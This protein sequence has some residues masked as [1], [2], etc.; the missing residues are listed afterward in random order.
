MAEYRIG[1]P[2][3]FKIMA[4]TTPLATLSYIMKISML[5]LATLMAAFLYLPLLTQAQ[6]QSPCEWHLQLTDSG[7]DGWD[8]SAIGLENITTG[9]FFFL[10]L[11]GFVDNGT[12]TTYTFSFAPGDEIEL[13]WFVGSA[14][15]EEIGVQLFDGSNNTV[16]SATNPTGGILFNTTVVCPPC[17]LPSNV[18]EENIYDKRVKIKWT[19]GTADLTATGW[20]VIYGPAGFVPSSGL[21]DSIYVATPK[22][23]ITSL[24]PKTFYDYYI[25]QD[26]GNG[27]L[28][29]MAGPFTFQTYWS[30]DVSV[31][32]ILTPVSDC[33]L[34]SETITFAMSNPGSNPQSLIPY[35]YWVNGVPGG[36]PQPEDGYYTGVIGKDS[37][38]V[39]E[40]ETPF[41][42][43][44]PIEY[45]I[46]VYTQMEGDEDNT[47]DTL[48][49]YV[50]NVLAPPYAQSFDKWNGGWTVVN[51]PNSFSDASWE[52]G[53]PNAP[54]IQQAGDGQ[55][56][57]VTNLDGFANFAELSYIEST[58]FDF[59][60]ITQSPAIEFLINYSCLSGD[61]GA[62]IDYTLNDGTSWV[63]IGTAAN[64]GA[65]W[66]NAPDPETGLAS[67]AFAG[68][69]NGWLK[70][71]HLAPTLAGKPDV[72]F[73]FGYREGFGTSNEGVGI[74]QFRVFVPLAV[75]GAAIK[76]RSQGETSTCGLANDKF[77]LNMVNVGGQ[78]IPNGYSLFYQVDNG[79]IDSVTISNNPL[80][81]DE[82]LNHTFALAFDSR[83]K[84]T[85]I[86]AWIRVPGDL[87]LSNDTIFYS[88][89][90]R[91]AELP[92]F[93]NFD[94]SFEIPGDWTTNNN[95]FVNNGHNNV[96]NVLTTNLYSGILSFEYNLPRHGVVGVGDSLKYD[97]RI[98]EFSFP[99]EATV[100]GTGNKMDV[101]VSTNCGTSFQ[102]IETI[103]SSNHVPTEDLTTRQI[104]LANFVGNS[105]IV[106]FKGTWSSGD[107]YFD[108]DNINLIACGA[109]MGLSAN[110]SPAAP[111]S[112]NGTASVNVGNGNPPY[113]YE[114][115]TGETTQEITGLA[116]GTYTV[117]VNDAHGCSDSLSVEVQVN[118]II[119]VPGFSRF[120]VRP[121]P[122]TGLLFLDVQFE[123]SVELQAE[124]INLL[125][126]RVWA[127][128]GGETTGLTEAIDLGNAP[129]GIYMLR[130]VANGQITTRKI[131]KNSSN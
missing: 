114:W 11:E 65:N 63:R 101:Q 102:T 17:A 15:P 48:R 5:R 89:D 98:V 20:W 35:N 47:N 54:I 129:N 51:D 86:K 28:S 72:R 23:T 127:S 31:T 24:M 93:E 41:D 78:G 40:F 117:F 8:G 64:T 75:D 125:G 46:T 39:I 91:A 14:N 73:R 7:G 104:S 105:I 49:Y 112:S 108:L 90:H 123:Q 94:S 36:V 107:Y 22:V 55:K 29:G 44:D 70:A 76:G 113:T 85:T 67:R 61:D 62:F 110:I 27:E 124:V 18:F 26:C 1:L 43:S 87:D 74:D 9:D 128:T 103:N 37:T 120:T 97:Y 68:E 50:N 126:Q 130:V 56:A 60:D 30:N 106:R 96:S 95:A 92:L 109:D 83:D 69:S 116:P 59:S 2:L 82:N 122:T 79:A 80:V 33:E 121:N 32:A 3:N 115:S 45:E 58:C 77:I 81:P 6:A 99:F 16:F 111:N 88:V 52:H 13:I 19:P 57:W 66:Y 53:V 10:Q 84:L 21:G 131:V 118:S 25:I 12:D 4:N 38:E 71:H 34:A 119:D 42:M 100:L